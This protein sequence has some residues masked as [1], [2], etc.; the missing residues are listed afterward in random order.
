MSSCFPYYKN[1]IPLET[2]GRVIQVSDRY[3]VLK[4][5]RYKWIVCSLPG[6]SVH[7]IL[8]ARILEWVAI[9]FSRGI[10]WP[11]D[12]TWVSWIA[13]RFFTI[14]AT[15]EAHLL[16]NNQPNTYK[17]QFLKILF[18]LSS[19]FYNMENNLTSLIVML[20]TTI[21]NS[22]ASV[23]F[24]QD[25]WPWPVV[26]LPKFLKIKLY[27]CDWHYLIIRCYHLLSGSW[28]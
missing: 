26:S 19:H 3:I 20:L 16:Q 12:W 7:G 5:G 27:F 28:C 8:Q 1:T 22:H 13:G 14:W 25:P 18:F 11:R 24:F 2:K 10:S 15:R 23:Y 9:R 6:S 21:I 4:N 17:Q